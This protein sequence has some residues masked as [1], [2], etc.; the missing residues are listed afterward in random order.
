MIEAIGIIAVFFGGLGFAYFG[1]YRH[2]QQDNTLADA[3]DLEA[4]HE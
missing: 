1:G 3:L 2:G 4:G